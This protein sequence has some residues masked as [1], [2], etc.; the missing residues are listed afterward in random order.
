MEKREA[1]QDTIEYFCNVED[2][3]N[4]REVDQSRP[5]SY[6]QDTIEAINI[7]QD[8]TVAIKFVQ[9]TIET[10]DECHDVTET[11]N[12]AITKDN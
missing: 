4:P 2:S 5:K 1:N 9:D 6:V 8:V 12:Y 3:T 7:G 10:T 11:M